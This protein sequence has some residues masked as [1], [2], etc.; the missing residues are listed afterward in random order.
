MEGR[1]EGRMEG[2]ME[3]RMEGQKD[4]RKEGRSSWQ[5]RVSCLVWM[6]LTSNREKYI[7]TEDQLV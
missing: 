6:Y 7:S 3:G 2:Q 4:G 5:A 1:T